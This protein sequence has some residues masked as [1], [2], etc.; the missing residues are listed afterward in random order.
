MEPVKQFPNTGS[1]DEFG[2]TNS[3]LFLG[4]AAALALVF[5]GLVV[6]GRR[7]A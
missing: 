2:D 7:A 4:A 5:A 1:G 3:A 6:R